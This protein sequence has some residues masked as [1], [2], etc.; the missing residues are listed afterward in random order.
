MRKQR[1]TLILFAIVCLVYGIAQLAMDM[2]RLDSV[3]PLSIIMLLITAVF[4]PV[5]LLTIA[6]RRVPFIG[7]KA[8]AKSDDTASP[9]LDD[10]LPV[11]DAL[12][13]E[14]PVSS[15]PDRP[16]VEIIPPSKTV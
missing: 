7:I 14:K 13:D 6:F 3:G 8:G 2:N 9:P 10:A 11:D 5:A 4:V 1:A 16:G 15:D 12:P